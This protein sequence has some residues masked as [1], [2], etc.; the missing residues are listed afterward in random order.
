MPQTNRW[1]DFRKQTRTPGSCEYTRYV[2]SRICMM[3]QA[4]SWVSASKFTARARTSK[5]RFIVAEAVSGPSGPKIVPCIPFKPHSAFENGNFSKRHST[6]LPDMMAKVRLR[7]LV[8]ERKRCTP[9]N[10][11]R[12]LALKPKQRALYPHTITI[13][14]SRQNP[15]TLVVILWRLFP[16][17]ALTPTREVC[18]DA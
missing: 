2:F 17:G 13:P 15:V 8:W 4:R 7:S 12:K 1:T 10:T 11:Q 14:V 6:R 9:T 5:K 16:L 3:F 18:R